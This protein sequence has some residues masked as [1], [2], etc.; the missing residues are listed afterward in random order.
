MAT[1]LGQVQVQ[2]FRDQLVTEAIVSEYRLS[3]LSV[4]CIIYVP[5][6]VH[7]ITQV[8]EFHSVDFLETELIIFSVS[9]TVD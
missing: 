4:V 7:T 6:Y 3:L 2:H 8:F 9:V 5:C 1:P